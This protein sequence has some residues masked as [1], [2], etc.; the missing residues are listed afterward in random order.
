MKTF[1]FV[2][3]YL[4]QLPQN[5]I[6]LIYELITS[7]E[8]F[9][10]NSDFTLYKNKLRGSVS[11]GDYIFIDKDSISNNRIIL[12]ELGHRQQSLILGPLY[13]LIIGLPSIIWAS[14]YSLFPS[15]YNRYSY[16]DFYTEKWANKLVGL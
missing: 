6:G 12:H 15:I 13:L 10:V 3:K 14:L 9:E 5:I 8:K 7:A 2:L 11:L 16:Y 1:I 4:W